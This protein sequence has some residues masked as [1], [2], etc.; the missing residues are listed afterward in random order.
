MMKAK[1]GRIINVASVVGVMGN[2]GQANYSASKAGVIGLTKT[3]AKEFASRNINVNAVAPGYIETEMTH[4]LSD[5]ARDAFLT[6]IPLGR[7][8]KPQDV[9]RVVRFLAS[10]DADYITGQTINIDGGMVM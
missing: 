7:G 4:K 10:E 6:H 3:T 9:A 5:E 1:A 2:A 8:G